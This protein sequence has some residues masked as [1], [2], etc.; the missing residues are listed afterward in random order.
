MKLKT[1][2]YQ[3][4]AY[5]Y[6][7]SRFYANW[8]RLH[9]FLFDRVARDQQLPTFATP[10]EIVPYLNGMVWRPDSWID[11]G[12]A[13]C[14]PQM[15]W[16]RY[17]NHLDHKIGDCDEF[18]IFLSNVIAKSIDEKKWTAPIDSPALLTVTWIQPDGVG[19]GHNVCLLRRTH[20]IGLKLY[21]EWGYMDYGKPL[22][23]GTK[24]RVVSAIRHRYVGQGVIGLCWAV[25]TPDLKLKEIHFG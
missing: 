14:S 17:I 8:S 19:S 6:I 9:R 23:A 7:G 5:L 11:A 1:L 3:L 10:E 20:R 18:A 16:Y 13:I 21:E 24:E 12:D 2:L 15:V 25:H 4:G 22:W